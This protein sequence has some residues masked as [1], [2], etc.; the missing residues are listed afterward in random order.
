[1][2]QEE[3]AYCSDEIEVVLVD[4]S[5]PGPA[6][7]GLDDRDTVK[8][9]ITM[10]CD[11]QTAAQLEESVKQRLLENTQVRTQVH[12]G[13]HHAQL[14]HRPVSR[15]KAQKDAGEG[16]VKIPVITFDSPEEEG[17]GGSEDES[18]LRQA[19]SQSE[20]FH[21]CRETASSECLDPEQRP[22]GGQGSGDDGDDDGSSGAAAGA[23]EPNADSRGF[24]RLPPTLGR[25]GPG[26]RTHIRGL[27]VD[28]GK[29]SVLPSHHSHHGVG[30]H[31]RLLFT[32]QPPA[33]SNISACLQAT[34]TTSKSDLEAKEGQ[35]PDESNF[36]EFV[37]LLG[38]LSTR[39]GG[40]STQEDQEAENEATEAKQAGRSC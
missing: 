10:S 12:S 1:M 39:A 8:I 3:E 28:S 27:S 6:P 23:L 22:A 33:G 21:L 14:L 11:P 35:L 24:L 32:L 16:H 36:L 18:T 34:M 26:G 17:D 25:C 37:S 29:D 20:E 2:E 19:T 38:S 30:P 40:S 4:N 7:S 31:F 13:K 15:F 5:G 9:V